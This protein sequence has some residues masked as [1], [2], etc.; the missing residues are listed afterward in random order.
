MIELK[1]DLKQ[2][3]DAVNKVNFHLDKVLKE[4]LNKG[5]MNAVRWIRSNRLSGRRPIVDGYEGLNVVT[6]R[7]R[8]SISFQET[9]KEGNAYITKI[10]TN[11]EYAPKHEFGEGVPKRPFISVGLR[12]IEVIKTYQEQVVQSIN[13]EINK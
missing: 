4:G 2:F 12:N 5:S 9:K 11:V 10:G 7:L 1:I 13:E 3:R 8:S 6:G